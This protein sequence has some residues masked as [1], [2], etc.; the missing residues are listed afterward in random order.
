MGFAFKFETD[1]EPPPFRSSPP[2]CDPHAGGL[3]WPE[4]I[5]QRDLKKKPKPAGDRSQRVFSCL[6][7]Q[8]SRLKNLRN[9]KI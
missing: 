7:S 5:G 3:P 2:S 1:A 9:E 8:I 6:E 4:V